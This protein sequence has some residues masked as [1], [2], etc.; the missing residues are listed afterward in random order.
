[1]IATLDLIQKAYGLFCLLQQPRGDIAWRIRHIQGSLGIEKS[2]FPELEGMDIDEDQELTDE[3][4]E[5][6]QE[7]E[8]SNGVREPSLNFGTSEKRSELYTEEWS[9][10]D[11]QL[12]KEEREAEEEN[13]GWW[14][15]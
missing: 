15:N 12:L 10:E 11:K 4:L 6:K 2:E 14:F 9:E 7:E 5:L 1:M 13:D 8:E 3:E